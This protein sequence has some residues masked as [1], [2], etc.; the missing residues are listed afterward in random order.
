M[1][2]MILNLNIQVEKDDLKITVYLE[3]GKY[4]A[5]VEKL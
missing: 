2:E 4:S 5:E 1:K 3:D